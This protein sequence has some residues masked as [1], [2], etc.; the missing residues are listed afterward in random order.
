MDL[1]LPPVAGPNFAVEQVG[2]SGR[3]IAC[4]ILPM[5]PI[6]GVDF[7]QG[8]FREKLYSA[9]CWS[10]SVPTRWMSSCLTWRPT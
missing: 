3:V 2:D 5:D 1:G 6:A 7:L 9:P 8:D 10:E 4:D